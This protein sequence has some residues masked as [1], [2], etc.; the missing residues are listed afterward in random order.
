MKVPYLDL[1]A[2]FASIQADLTA[3]LAEIFQSN[4]YVLGPAVE[5]FE[6][7]FAAFC[8]S[9]HCVGTNN[10]TSALHLAL[11]AAGVG[12]GDEVITQA[13]TFIATVAAI[14]YTGATP[15]LVDIAEPTYTIDCDAIEAAVTRRTKVILPVHLFGQPCDLDRIGA[16]AGRQGI[17]V[18]EDASQAHGA[19]Y[20]G[21]IVGS[22]NTATFSFYPGKNLGAAGEAGAVVTHDEGVASRMRMLRNHGSSRKYVHDAVGYNYRLEGLQAAVLGVKLKH[23][24]EWTERRKAVAA[25]YDELLPNIGKPSALAGTE[26][27][28]HVYPVFVSERPDVVAA[29]QASGIETNVHYPIP[30]HLQPGYAALGYRAGD[31]PVS[32]TLAQT[33]LSLPIY[34]ELTD[35]QITFVA[36]ALTS[37]VAPSSV[38]RR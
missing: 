25:R 9:T 27:A 37:A 12:P 29:L 2:Q 3:A 14:L 24:E 34:P 32:E 5:R 20:A 35:E 16:I 6:R 38:R 18:I 36:D 22:R 10:G 7:D 23:L 33:E 8:C 28:N 17:T 31:F 15:V 11:L 1:T 19:R 4:S 26:S 30:C 21:Q 13:N